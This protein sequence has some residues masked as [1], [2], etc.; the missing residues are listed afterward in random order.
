MRYAVWPL[1]APPIVLPGEA[2][3]CYE[4]YRPLRFGL[5]DTVP[6]GFVTDGA[7]IPRP[8]WPLIGTPFDPDLLPGAIVHDWMYRFGAWSRA[9][10]DHRLRQHLRQW[11]VGVVRAW[12]VWASVRLF[13]WRYWMIVRFDRGISG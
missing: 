10:A 13:G 1:M 7:S 6:R 3:G 12:L 4:L 2:P 11:S 5:N 8:L 9:E